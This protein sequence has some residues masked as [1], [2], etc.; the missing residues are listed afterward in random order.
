[1]IKVR[2]AGDRGHFDFGWL[3][4]NHS[5]SFGE[6][7][8]PAHMGFRSLRVLNED[9]VLPGKGFGRHGTEVAEGHGLWVQVAKGRISIGQKTGL[10]AGDGAALEGERKI[11]IHAETDSEFLV[12]DLA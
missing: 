10:A 6:Y 5:F 3:D 2:E 7:H 9:Q 12:F 11:T 1:L 8:D 4:T